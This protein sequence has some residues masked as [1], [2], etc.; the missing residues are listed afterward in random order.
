MSFPLPLPEP[1]RAAVRP[2]TRVLLGLSGGLDSAMALG[3][4]VL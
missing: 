1:L 4:I 3:R 2:G